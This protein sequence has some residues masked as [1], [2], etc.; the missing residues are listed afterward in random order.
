MYFYSGLPLPSLVE[1]LQKFCALAEEYGQ[2]YGLLQLLPLYQNVLNLTGESNAESLTDLSHGEA[3]RY[4]DIVGW[5]E[6]TGKETERSLAMQVAFY[7]GDIEKATSMFLS[8][9]DTNASGNLFKGIFFDQARVFFFS[10]ICMAK[11][12]TT[13]KYKWLKVAKKYMEM[14]RKWTVN[15]KGI[16]LTHKLMILKA[17]RMSIKDKSNNIRVAFDQAI[18]AASKTGY[19]QDAALAALLASRS[20][21]DPQDIK[22]YHRRALD[23]FE[24]WGAHGLVKYLFNQT[25]YQ[26]Q[27]FSTLQQ[28]SMKKITSNLRSRERFDDTVVKEHQNLDVSEKQSIGRNLG[29]N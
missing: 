13:K 16:N 14:I 21:P 24:S 2:K 3:K 10:L 6:R 17:E 22:S 9:K 1:D 5:D 19:L 8:L 7:C 18:A 11:F 25:T 12:K 23:L 15:S 29:N 27:D 20:L 28:N 26:S 4:R